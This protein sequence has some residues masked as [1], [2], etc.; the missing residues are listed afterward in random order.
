[1]CTFQQYCEEV[2]RLETIFFELIDKMEKIDVGNKTK[3]YYTNVV[4]RF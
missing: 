1:M 3:K 2:E 4:I